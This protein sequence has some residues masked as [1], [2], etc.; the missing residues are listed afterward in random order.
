MPEILKNNGIYSH[1]VSDHQHYWEDGGAT[2]HT[3]YRSWECE[4]G[5]E[6][7]PWKGDLSFENAVHKT[8]FGP[9]PHNDSGINIQRQ[10]CVNRSYIKKISDFPQEKTFADGIEFIEKNH[11]YDNWFLQ[12]ETFDPHEPFFVDDKFREI[13]QKEG[14][15]VSEY[16]WP[17]YGPATESQSF[18][19]GMRNRY[20]A[21]LSMCDN[22]L[23]K[24]LDLMDQYQMWEDTMLI[25]NTDHG[26]MLGEHMWW[27]KSIM[28][29][30]DELAHI[31]MFIWD[32]RSGKQ[33]ERRKSLVQTIDLAPTILDFFGVD[34]PK[35]M[36]G[37]ALKDT[38]AVDKPVRKYALFG[39]FGSMIHI[40]DGR[41]VYMRAPETRENQPLIEYTL[42]PTMMRG[43][44]P[45]KRLRNAFLQEPFTF[46]KECPVLAVPA[47]EEGGEV[48]PCYRF[49][50]KL[51]DLERDAKEETPVSDSKKEA[52]LA[53]A[54]VRLMRE[55]DAPK[56]QFVRMG[57]PQEG[58]V[59][60][61]MVIEEREKRKEGEVLKSLSDYQWD[62][63]TMWQFAALENMTS[64][65]ME[66]VKLE[67]EFRKFME[68]MGNKQVTKKNIFSFAKNVFPG[69]EL[70]AGL[71]TLEMAGRLV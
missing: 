69:E 63:G 28:P 22:S 67:S 45:E 35:D 14:M 40:T 51:Y 24:I 34:I 71:F 46:T 10:D 48:A 3:R 53:T 60:E 32:P 2:Y 8:A 16:D 19:E 47:M 11:G 58:E 1:L 43:R 70:E 18:V 6:G 27:A 50:N 68:H 61:D 30:Y 42:M 41:Y 59:T 52:E 56:E 49:G 66:P 33:K 62:D 29:L 64:T 65:F 54:M 37:I 25:V 4:R 9:R 39:I 21:L 26:Y 12:I 57:L 23:G 44:M 38:I 13:Y 17:P 31:P 7:D 36:Q 20:R 15:E 5:Q 55:N